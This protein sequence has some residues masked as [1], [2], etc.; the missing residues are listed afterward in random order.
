MVVRLRDLLGQ[1]LS[2]LVHPQPQGFLLLLWGGQLPLVF[3]LQWEEEEGCG[4]PVHLVCDRQIAELL[5]MMTMAVNG[6]QLCPSSTLL[7]WLV[8]NG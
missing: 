5:I 1:D 2:I 3:M 6:R 8:Q 4:R 7:T